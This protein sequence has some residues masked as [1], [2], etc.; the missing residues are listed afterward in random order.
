MYFNDDKIKVI[1]K[2]MKGMYW[3]ARKYGSYPDYV[4]LNPEQRT[5]VTRIKSKNLTI[6]YREECP[7]NNF[8]YTMEDWL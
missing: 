2:V 1:D 3:F 7:I 8:A 6:L 4:M 5:P